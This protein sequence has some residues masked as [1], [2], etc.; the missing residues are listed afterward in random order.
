MID[1]ELFFVI[2]THRLRDV[3]E[4]IEQYDEN[5][6]RNGHSV[7]II[8]FDDSSPANHEKYFP[9]LEQTQRITKF[10][11]SARRRRSNFSAI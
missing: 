11:T 8:V 7:P 9:L 1:K 4:T 6:W 10:I 5:L 3:G 2:P